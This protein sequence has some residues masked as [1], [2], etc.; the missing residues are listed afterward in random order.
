MPTTPLLHDILTEICK[1][2]MICSK[3][4]DRLQSAS[5]KTSRLDLSDRKREPNLCLH[6]SCT[7]RLLRYLTHYFTG[8]I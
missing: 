6:F 3:C 8:Y 4:R 7:V 1:S 5:E 2:D